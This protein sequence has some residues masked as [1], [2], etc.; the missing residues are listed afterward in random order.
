MQSLTRRYVYVLALLSLCALPGCEV[1]SQS[2][3]TRFDIILAGGRVMNPE[4]GLDAVRYV[5]IQGDRIS[6][7]STQPLEGT[8]IVDVRG[9]VVAPGF[10][11]LH[12]HG[13]T[14]EA[15]EF[16]VH[17][18]VT[19][20]LELEGGMPF[21]GAFIRSR[22]GKALINFGATAGHGMLRTTVMPEFQEIGNR[23]RAELESR[24][25]GDADYL[26]LMKGAY[27]R[28]GLEGLARL[29]ESFESGLREGALGIG[30][31]HQY[32]P[33]ATHEEIYRV[34]E[35]A[36]GWEVPIFTHVRAM[37]IDAMQEV[38][39]NAAATGASLHIVHVN[40]MSLGA[41][42]TVL[43]LIAG[44]QQRG[45][46]VTTEAYPY[47]AA[48]TFLQ[49]AIFD[50]GWRER[51]QISYRDLQWQD[52]GERL[53]QET[54]ETYR[55]KGGVVIIHM[56][57]PEWIELAMRTPFV[58]IGSDGMPYAPGAHPRGAGTFSR[59]LGRYVREQGVLTLME[60]LRKM[61]LM[62]ARRLEGIAPSMKNKGRIKVGADADI[63]VFDPD[64]ILDTATFENGLS[65]SQGIEH[66][67]VHGTFV[68]REGKTVPGAQPGRPVLGRYR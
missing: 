63:T 51:M 34:F 30:M 5:G 67:L 50:E 24:P 29:K 47:T 39:A 54:F 14:N 44:A 36:E 13:Q 19:T 11:D 46:D 17:D 15:N 45:L 61:T 40:S 41:L 1:Y 6:E 60:A 33:G 42:P 58:M 32:F 16:Q 52:T 55:E 48:S 20:A 23:L 38:I 35:M 12:A 18:G 37:R 4:S 25:F 57:K 21:V 49:S 28:L 65:F 59:V 62:P 9:L 27:E 10:I 64:K 22:A 68:V 26:A 43:E 31:E 2:A 66:V 8:T 7:I 53:T 3:A 56:M